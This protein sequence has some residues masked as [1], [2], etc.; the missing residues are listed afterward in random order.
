MSLIKNNVYDKQR[1]KAKCKVIQNEM[2]LIRNKLEKCQKT[3]IWYTL[4]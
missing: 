3:N 2:L 4:H 1:K